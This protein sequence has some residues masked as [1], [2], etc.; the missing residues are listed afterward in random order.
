MDL[1]AEGK[2]T[3]ERGAATEVF[4]RRDGEWINTGWQLART[5]K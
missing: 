3:T 1:Q 2:R 4:V 5:G